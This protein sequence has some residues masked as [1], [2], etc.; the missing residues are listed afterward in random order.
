MPAATQ[1]EKTGTDEGMGARLDALER[2]VG[3]LGAEVRTRRLVVV[4]DD[5]N[6]RIVGEVVRATAEFR[7]E[8]PGGESGTHTAVVLFASPVAMGIDPD[9]GD[10]GATIGLH[11]W[12]EGDAITEVDA[13]PGEDGRWRP[14][15]HLS[16]GS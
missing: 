8:L 7:L 12:A 15:L 5:G 3:A 11:L 1:T 10:L 4:D 16:G 9:E 14:H 2:A 6:E 13:W